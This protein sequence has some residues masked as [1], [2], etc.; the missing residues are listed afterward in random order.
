[1]KSLLYNYLQPFESYP[2]AFLVL[3]GSIVESTSLKQITLQA[4]FSIYWSLELLLY[5]GNAKIDEEIGC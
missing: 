5:C 1:M 4:G 2:Y 3:L